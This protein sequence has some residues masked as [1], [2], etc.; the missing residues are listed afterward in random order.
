[1]N[2]HL[3]SLSEKHKNKRVQLEKKSIETFPDIHYGYVSI[4]WLIGDTNRHLKD[5]H[6]GLAV[7]PDS[8][9]PKS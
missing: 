5:F 8:S 6:V 1:M 7:K 9:F 2:V 3:N 4:Y